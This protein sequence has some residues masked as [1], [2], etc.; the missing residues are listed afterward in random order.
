[1]FNLNARKS[2]KTVVLLSPVVTTTH[3]KH[4]NI[5]EP[6]LNATPTPELFPFVYQ[7]CLQ[8][9]PSLQFYMF[10]RA[11]ITLF[12]TVYKSLRDTSWKPVA[13]AA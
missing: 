8:T 2:P 6:N 12:C 3:I 7:P 1:M 4:H 13:K 9:Q 10:T 5:P 11:P